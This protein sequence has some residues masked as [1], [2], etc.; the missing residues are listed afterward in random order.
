MKYQSLPIAATYRRFLALNK[1]VKRMLSSGE[2]KALRKD[3]QQKLLLSIRQLFQRL[4]RVIPQQRL[5]KAL[6]V[7]ALMLG[8]SSAHAQQFENP[9]ENPFGLGVPQSDEIFPIPQF[10]DID[11]DGDYD[12]FHRSVN[13]DG[14]NDESILLFQANTGTAEAP[15]FGEIVLN[16]FGVESLGYGTT[17]AFGDL[18][19]DGDYDL[20]TGNYDIEYNGDQ[21]TYYENIGTASAPSFAAPVNN[22]FGLS[23]NNGTDSTI[24]FFADLDN[25]GDLDLLVGTYSYDNDVPGFAYFPNTGTAQAPAFGQPQLNPF[26]L[27]ASTESYL[28]FPTIADFDNDG[29]LDI[30]AGGGYEYEGDYYQPSL[31]YYENTGTPEQ[32]AFAAPQRNSFGLLSGNNG[33][34]VTPTAAD[35]DGDGD[36][37]VLTS[38]YYQEPG[39]DLSKV[40]FEYFENAAIINSTEGLDEAAQLF[41]LFPTVASNV[42]QW[43][44]ESGQNHNGSQVTIY[45]LNGRALIE[46]ELNGESGSLSVTAL[47]AGLYH[48]RL[49]DEKGVLLGV[50]QIV[51]Q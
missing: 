4:H 20:L 34:I 51:K 1:K 17:L 36:I 10:V 46:Q 40:V 38:G 49:M 31:D 41:H 12:L 13:A 6:A 14:Y 11:G 26:G 50:R 24:P 48:A 16:D 15:A 2:F 21:F 47:P 3:Q 32:A 42:V 8:L 35:L 22:P 33:Y 23:L 5:R 7:S 28:V 43:Q 29:D 25:D 18:D 19:G 9:V 39:T 37:D 27:E 44:V 45:D 30:I